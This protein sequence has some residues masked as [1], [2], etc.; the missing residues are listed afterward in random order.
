[1]FPGHIFLAAGLGP[2]RESQRL[3][4]WGHIVTFVTMSEAL[5]PCQAFSTKQEGKKNYIL[6]VH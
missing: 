3:C 5:S 6:W 2:E 4:V 1:M